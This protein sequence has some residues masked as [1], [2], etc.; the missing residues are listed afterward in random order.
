MTMTLFACKK[1]LI[2]IEGYLVD[3]RN[4]G[5]FNP[6]ND[7]K[8]RLVVDG[9]YGYY[10]ELG[11][12]QVD[13]NGYYKIITKQKKVGYKARLQLAVSEN[14]HLNKDHFITVS[15]HVNHDFIIYCEVDLNRVL[16]NQSSGNFDSVVVNVSNSK[17]IKRYVT[18]L[19]WAYNTLNIGNIRGDEKNY[20]VSTIYSNNTVF[21]QKFDTIY[22]GCHTAVTDTIWY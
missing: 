22:S 19:N 11:S 14:W 3:E 21:A 10:D 9:S 1:E 2:T 5:H 4:G 15:N 12:S 17:G 8:V 6:Y 20:L 13:Q 16:V 18:Q 7:A